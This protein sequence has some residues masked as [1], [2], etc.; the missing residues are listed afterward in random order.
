MKKGTRFTATAVAAI[1]TAAALCS[2]AG[3]GDSGKVKLE[4]GNWIQSSVKEEDKQ[5][6]AEK[7]TRYNE[8]Y[9]DIEVI[10]GNTYQYDTKTFN[11][12][13]AAG[14]LPTFLETYFTEIPLIRKN[15]YAADVTKALKDNGLL[16]KINPEVLEVLTDENGKICGMPSYTY[17]QGLIMNKSMFKAAGLVEADG[18]PKIPQT[19]EEVGEFSKIIR[20]KTGKA[21]FVT[22]TT[23]N[24]G[25]WLF[26]NIAWS[27]GVEFEE[28]QED[29]TWKA[30]FDS[31][32]F[33]DALSYVYD[34]RWKYNALPD[35]KVLNYTDYLKSFATGQAAMTISDPNSLRELPKQYGLNIDDIYIAKL[36]A[37]PKGRYALMGGGFK[38]FSSKNTDEQNDAAV[39]WLMM[40]GLTPDITPE[41]EANLRDGY[42]TQLENGSI[43][44]PNALFPVWTNEE[45]TAKMEEILSDYTN[46]DPANIADFNDFTGVTIHPEE[47]VC[48]QQLYSV[49][50][51]VI[52]AVMTNENADID[53]LTK[54]AANDFQQNH[55][56]KEGK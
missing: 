12:R 31:Q 47:S 43:I 50:D 33:R 1:M 34:L 32:E 18:T 51:G 19:W 13:A 44:F 29:G 27:Y 54:T 49:L 15:N 38:L 30:K 37:G 26:M 4:V 6:F 8:R 3:G 21:G 42:E 14:Q 35:D 40:D 56:D 10:T 22:A 17:A 48:C 20:E 11:A 45:Y 5:K 23:D 28:L 41:I 24:C 46:F 36:P 52:Q 55:L 2:C 39:K 9:P 7:V 53:A 25:G 16:D